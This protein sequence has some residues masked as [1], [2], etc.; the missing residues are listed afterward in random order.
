[1]LVVGEGRPYLAALVVLNGAEWEQLGG[2][3]LDAA[4]AENLLLARIAARMAN[5]PGYARIRRV[6]VTA[7]PWEVANGLLT[8]TLKLR[9]PQLFSYYAAEIAALYAGH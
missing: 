1:M 4:A 5:F 9:R 6:Q 7:T 3:D 8:P 2:N